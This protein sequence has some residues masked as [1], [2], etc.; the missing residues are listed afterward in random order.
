MATNEN[1]TGNTVDFNGTWS[2]NSMSTNFTKN[3]KYEV[4]IFYF[5][6]KVPHNKTLIQATTA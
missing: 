5:H 3:S 2:L 4:L 1:Y 6:T